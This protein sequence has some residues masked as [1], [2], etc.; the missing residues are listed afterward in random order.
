MQNRHAVLEFLLGRWAVSKRLDYR[1]GGGRGWLQGEAT[2]V[3]T[4]VDDVLLMEERGTLK[5]DSAP[6]SPL[7][8]YRF[9]V[10]DARQWPVPDEPTSVWTTARPQPV[11]HGM[12]GRGSIADRFRGRAKK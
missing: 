10:F 8:A 2:I 11:A 1:I 9:Y 4:E 6:H 5:M 12:G 3:A 7:S